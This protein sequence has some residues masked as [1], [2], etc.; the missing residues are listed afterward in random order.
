MPFN[1]KILNRIILLCV[2]SIYCL[3]SSAQQQDAE[4]SRIS[5]LIEKVKNEG[6]I[7]DELSENNLTN[8]PI[9]IKKTIS[10]NTVIIAIDSALI[11]PQGMLINA[12]TEITLPSAAIKIGLA[13]K[14]VLVTPSGISPDN[15]RLALI[16]EYEIPISNMVKL[17]L[18]GDG[19]N[20]IEWDCSGFRSVNL[21]GLFEFS[22]QYFIPDTLSANNSK[23][24]AT[25]E[26]NTSDLNNILVETSISPFRIKNMGEMTFVVEKAS[27]DMSDFM[28][29]EDFVLPAGY[30]NT[31]FDDLRLWRGFFLKNLTV[32][33]PPELSSSSKRTSISVHNILIDESGISGSFS[34]TNILPFKEGNA[35]GWPFS[36]NNISI[37][38]T[39]NKLTGGELEG[40][41]SIPFLGNDTLGY[42]AQIMSA[43]NGLQYYFAVSTNT[44]RAFNFPLGGKVTL[45]KGCIYAFDVK[46]GKF[47]PSAILNGKINLSTD[48]VKAEG[49]K[50]ERLYVTAESPY[51]LGGKFSSAGGTGF[52]LAGFGF[53]VDSISL[54]VGSGKA[55]LAFN[56]RIALM[57]ASEKGI[58]ASTRF[59]VN[60]SVVNKPDN[61]TSEPKQHWVYDGTLVQ[62][63]AIDASISVFKMK[64]EIALL[65]GD[66]TY[67]DGF[68]GNVSFAIKKILEK[69][70]DVEVYFGTKDDFRYW[71]TKIN[72]PVKINVG[73]VII[74]EKMIGGAYNRM[75]KKNLLAEESIYI[76]DPKSGLG[77][78]TG[79]GLAVVK[80]Q[81]VYTESIFEIAFNSSGGVRYI[82]FTGDGQFFSGPE[83]KGD[84][85]VKIR[86]VML[87]DNDNDIF[88]A[89]LRVYMNI[90]NVMKGMGPNNLLGEA[91]IHSDPKDWY[92]YIGRPS[93]PF[94]VDVIGLLKV[95]SYFM[96]GTCI[97]NMPLPPSE[98]S[99]IIGN[100]DL[101]FTKKENAVSTG[102]G[103]VFGMNFKT[104]FGFGKNGGFVY[105]Y[106]AAGAGSDIMLRDYG[107]VHCA[108]RSGSIGVDGWYGS[109]QGYAYLQG[110]IGIR[111]KKKEFDIMSVAAALLLQAK[112]P[113]PTWFRGNIAAR[114]NILG[115]LVK[116]KVNVEV[117]LGEECV[118]LSNGKELENIKIIGDIK[119]SEGNEQ[120]DVFASPQVAFNTSIDKEFGMVNID[121]QYNVYRV[122][123]D[124]FLVMSP[125]KEFIK[126]TVQ[127][128]N[129]HDVAIY[130][131][132][133]ILPGQQ[134]IT[135]KV[136]VHIEKK[137]S[138]GWQAL[139]NSGFI[140][141]ETSEA[142]FSTGDEPKSI[143][144][145]NVVYSY[146]LKN[147]Y[148]FYKD[149][150]S[151]GYIKLGT[152]QPDLFKSESD[153]KKWEYV[154]I[155]KAAT[156]RTAESIVTY[157]ESDATVLFN[158]PGNL[159]N[160]DVYTMTI[161]KK[162]AYT[163][164]I[165]KNLQ[166]Q[167]IS[168]ETTNK[169]DTLNISQNTLNG[170][171]SVNSESDLHSYSFR[172]SI[173]PTFR[174]K[175]DNITN[176]E[177]Q[178]AV[179]KTLMSVLGIEATMQETFDLYE[180]SGRSNDFGPL[181]YAEAK[182][183]NQWLDQHVNPQVYEL[184]GSTSGLSLDRNTDK[185][186][187]FPI[188]AMNVF[189]FGNQG[190]LLQR[191]QENAKNGNI[192]I[193]YWIPHYVYTDFAE[194]RNK[195]TSLFLNRTDV[196][197]QA[198]RLITGYINDIYRGPYKFTLNYRLPGINKITTSKEY[199]I[200]Y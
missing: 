11:T 49:L 91:V 122:K 150:Y 4:E 129:N 119:P 66:T 190:Y 101:D 34:A 188:K 59:R 92:I 3:H 176:W 86:M 40:G 108:G 6:R 113:N 152:G 21:H 121:D 44:S 70:A 82:S 46:N 32:Y 170:N 10:G 175:L 65:R 2:V 183:G 50:F 103:V 157:N 12:Y 99:S 112:M 60:A 177:E 186:G 198:Q 137:T 181:V 172:T 64:G 93:L 62:K 18:P 56:V 54:G 168:I 51:F 146:P 61:I 89:N 45:D 23:V 174:A 120:V 24:T 58:S 110:K 169:A 83:P 131:L 184:Y 167:R 125:G 76:P 100:I 87:Y 68:H 124:D 17:K 95:Q 185:L 193:R 138:T 84:P 80:D 73:P 77:F 127:W 26:V 38:I 141:Y 74:L 151:Q 135:T 145:N 148:N 182:L 147:Q 20:Y 159:V 187:L 1:R 191:E 15:S 165:D 161:V 111:V 8:L 78:M 37:G 69:P 160:A 123:L 28:N 142:K 114:Y 199:I 179:D 118:I 19:S 194:L 117:V 79:V 200:N 31:Y 144:D 22:D 158:I 143:S 149:E 57:N 126:G 133:N 134:Q 42:T 52:K 30:Q 180:L 36:I 88:H 136:K 53:G 96:A 13:A 105:A 41:L 109:G 171:I 67:G 7:V 55:S 153:G 128:N 106:F 196:T 75:R 90:A 173:Y 16:S 192:I 116:G 81:L 155:F 72:I 14:N 102:K 71:F 48:L 139:T 85:P 98:V 27:V 162:P 164:T 156:G 140:D 35:S 163:G 39:Q 197:L 5:A 154:A 47:V 33:L 43:N 132:L 63:I 25:F 189:N 29:C 130:K 9:G 178:Y 166:R 104:D 97:E 115:G 94:G 195:A 107:E